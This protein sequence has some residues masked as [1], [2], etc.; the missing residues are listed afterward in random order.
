M[1]EMI[2]TLRGLT[3]EIEAR[4]AGKRLIVA[5]AGAPGSGKSTLSDALLAE[6]NSSR[7]DRAALMAMDGYHFDNDILRARNLMPRKGAP[8]TF[9]AEGMA[10]DLDRIFQ[11][12]QDVA[13]PVF[14]RAADLARAHARI[15]HKAARIVLVEGNYLLLDR[16]PWRAMARFFGLTIF[17]HVP[18]AELERRL[19]RRWL[20]LAHDEDQANAR[21]A[22]NDMANARLV[23]AQSRKAD[24]G[25]TLA[26]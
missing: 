12:I 3:A 18:E 26:G 25:V 7:A 10:A 6:L 16:D 4:S 13:V 9:N 8:E 22:G 21:A 1:P 17:L 11:G 15:V 5:V 14:D 24:I 23:I 20:D 19:I 2:E